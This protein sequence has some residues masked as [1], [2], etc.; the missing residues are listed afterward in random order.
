[1]Q[2]R[3]K[4]WQTSLATKTLWNVPNKC[5]WVSTSV[6]TPQSYIKGFKVQNKPQSQEGG[7]MRQQLHI[8]HDWNPDCHLAQ[9]FH[10]AMNHQCFAITPHFTTGVDFLSHTQLVEFSKMWNGANAR[11]KYNTI[12]TSTVAGHLWGRQNT[13]RYSPVFFFF[14][15]ACRNHFMQVKW[16]S[17]FLLS[18]KVVRVFPVKWRV[19]ASWVS[20]L[21]CFLTTPLSSYFHPAP[22]F[23]P[24]TLC[25][26]TPV[27]IRVCWVVLAVSLLQIH[28]TR[29]NWKWDYNPGL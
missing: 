5:I 17:M 3:C 14:S 11:G 6:H 16:C 23:H 15:C 20:A 8:L 9:L 2:E 1:M 29:Q 13:K 12:S 18:C 28:F 7:R 4:L 21:L 10:C 27:N 26:A 25:C 19:N 24:S 22:S